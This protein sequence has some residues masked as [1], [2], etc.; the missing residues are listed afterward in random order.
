MSQLFKEQREQQQKGLAQVNGIEIPDGRKEAVDNLLGKESYEKTLNTDTPPARY[1]TRNFNSHTIT[2][3]SEPLFST[4]DALSHSQLMLGTHYNYSDKNTRQLN[5]LSPHP[6]DLSSSTK[7]DWQAVVM[8]YRI[9][10]LTSIPSYVD[11]MDVI[12]IVAMKWV[13]LG[14]HMMD[15][16]SVDKDGF[17]TCFFVPFHF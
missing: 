15:T 16:C 6:T 17:G 2:D 12:R 1:D 9:A 8:K 4:Q 13:R 10:E 7:A 5:S 11:T 14:L 3:C